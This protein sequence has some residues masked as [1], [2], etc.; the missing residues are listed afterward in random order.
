M[1]KTIPLILFTLAIRLC[2]AQYTVESVPNPKNIDGG[3]VSNPDG[4]L[5][6]DDVSSINVMISSIENQSTAQIAVVVLKSI[7]DLAPKDFANQLFNKWGVGQKGKNNG[8]LLLVVMEPKRWEFE[9]G[10]GLEGDLPDV[11]LFRIGDQ[12]MVPFFKQEQY[13]LGILAALRK[14]DEI[15]TNPQAAQGFY[16]EPNPQ[17]YTSAQPTYQD[18][19]KAKIDAQIL[20]II[21]AIAEIIIILIA[22][23]IRRRALTNK[24]QKAIQ[25]MNGLLFHVI[26]FGFPTVVAINFLTLDSLFDAA[27]IFPFIF[28][29][30]TQLLVFAF[31]SRV[32]ANFSL[33]SDDKY[34]EY[35]N[36]KQDHKSIWWKVILFPVVFVPYLIWFQFLKKK[37]RNTPRVSASGKVMQ[38]LDEKTDDFYLNPSQILE[39]QLKSVDYDVWLDTGTESKVEGYR[40]FLSKYDNCERCNYVTKYLKSD[41][42]IIPATYDSSG[43]GLKTYSCKNCHHEYQKTYTIP[44]KTRSSSSGSGGS[45]GGS[46]FGGGSSGGGG[47]G[48][49]W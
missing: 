31:A 1:K 37:L 42:T 44:R 14:I 46:S 43:E 41:V 23:F 47:A 20:Y 40:N 33:R 9:T 45:S 4:I 21:Y 32:V 11:I 27:S 36:L 5:S 16:S 19:N 25:P 17:E 22:L 2:F 39:E 48:G 24:K 34:E 28:L 29:I 12:L 8:L 38:K 15:L 18:R 35:K 6:P 13:G 3:W 7:G 26:L 10:Y 49:S 30:Y